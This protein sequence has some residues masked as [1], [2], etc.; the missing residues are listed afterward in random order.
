MSTMKPTKYYSNKQEHMIADCLGWSVVAASGARRFEPGDIRSDDYL[1]ECKTHMSE[2]SDIV[3]YK[4]VWRKISSEAV[5]VMK[6]PVL[7]VD[8]GTQKIKNT[9]CVTPE[10]FLPDKRHIQCDIMMRESETKLS[11]P[12][13]KWNGILD[14]GCASFK[15]NGESLL[16]MKLETFKNLFQE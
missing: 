13:E 7:F 11:F 8:N 10:R 16:L 14:N 5:S 1:G 2:Q 12:H 3:I 4:D 15:I 9:W 6:R